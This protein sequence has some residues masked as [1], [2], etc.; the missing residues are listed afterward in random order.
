MYIGKFNNFTADGTRTSI[1]QITELS[2]SDAANYTCEVRRRGG[3]EY[4]SRSQILSF[5]GTCMKLMHIMAS[6]RSLAMQ[7]RDSYSYII[8]NFLYKPH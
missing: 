8:L 5:Q 6:L 1:L 3:G 7:L 2:V 4:V